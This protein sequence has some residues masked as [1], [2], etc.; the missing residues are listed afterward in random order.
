MDVFEAGNAGTACKILFGEEGMA[1]ED[2]REVA[3][4]ISSIS[5]IM[6]DV[7]DSFFPQLLQHL[8]E[9]LDR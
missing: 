5:T 4:A 2:P 1:S 7:P 9:L 3:G 6:Q 8:E